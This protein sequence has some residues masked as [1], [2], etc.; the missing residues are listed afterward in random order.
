MKIINITY[1]HNNDFKAIFVCPLC[2]YKYESWGYSDAN[3]YNNVMP[4][5]ICPKCG[6]NEH[7]EGVEE[8]IKRVGRTYR[9]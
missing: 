9:I 5:A 7:G 3:F 6:K 4:N 1:S 2:C 8:L